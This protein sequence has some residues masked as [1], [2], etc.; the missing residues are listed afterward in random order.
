MTPD[1]PAMPS[2]G[3]G[4]PRTV[5]PYLALASGL[6]VAI[7][8]VLIAVE[9]PVTPLVRRAM[10]NPA[11]LFAVVMAALTLVCVIMAGFLSWAERVGRRGAAGTADSSHT[12][13][14]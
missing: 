14:S 7:L 2:A 13:E 6:E 5:L 8:Y 12:T 10:R 4:A 11:G 3:G 1:R 9:T